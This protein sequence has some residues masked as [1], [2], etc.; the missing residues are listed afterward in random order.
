MS[1]AHSW[2]LGEMSVGKVGYGEQKRVSCRMPV[3]I[4]IKTSKEILHL[5]F[6][7]YQPVSRKK[8]LT[9]VSY[10]IEAISDWAWK[11]LALSFGHFPFY[12]LENMSRQFFLFSRSGLRLRTDLRQAGHRRPWTTTTRKTWLWVSKT[13]ILAF[14]S[15]FLGI[16][17]NGN[18]N[19]HQI[20]TLC[21]IRAYLACFASSCTAKFF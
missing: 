8:Y 20:R 6:S 9:S 14:Q 3:L 7:P 1:V 15:F 13:L 21:S 5:L 18:M 19:I 2:D 11:T 4:T 12:S 17:F 16:A 10:L